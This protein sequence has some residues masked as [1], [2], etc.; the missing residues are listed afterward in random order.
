MSPLL[1]VCLFSILA[2]V[3]AQAPGPANNNPNCQINSQGISG[4]SYYY[5]SGD[6]DDVGIFVYS[7]NCD[8]G[9]YAP[10]QLQTPT[11]S[12]IDCGYLA[13]DCQE[14]LVSCPNFPRGSAGTGYYE[15]QY[16]VQTCCYLYYDFGI[17]HTQVTETAA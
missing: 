2:L 16:I 8:P 1:I 12:F 5:S 13:L 11:G 7:S 4:D 6:T 10:V 17:S 14:Y 15:F 3:H 9:S